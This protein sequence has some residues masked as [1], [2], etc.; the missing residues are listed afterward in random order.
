MATTTPSASGR[1]TPPARR[2][3]EARG[4]PP[5]PPAARSAAVP[6]E[7][8]L[9]QAREDSLLQLRIGRTAHYYTVV[10]YLLFLA[11]GYAIVAVNPYTSPIPLFGATYVLLAPVFGA[12][13]V[14]LFGLW[15]KWE[16]YQL[17]PWEF[18]FWVTVVAV[19]VSGFGAY[20]VAAHL[21]GFGPT[22]AY[23]LLPD[24]VPL[25][26]A[27][28]SL[29]LVGL[30]L[31]WGEWTQ[32]KIAAVTASLLPVLLALDLFVPGSAG[33]PTVLTLTLV[34]GGGLYLVAGSILHLI[35]S[36][37]HA[38][39][40]EMIISGQSRLFRFSDDLR[41]REEALRFRE[42]ALFRREA[43]V[44]V[45]E[46]ALA[47]RLLADADV[48]EQLAQLEKELETRTQ[49]IHEN[50]RTASLKLS[51]ATQTE[52]ELA[53]REAQLQLREQEVIRRETG[54]NERETALAAGE[55]ALVRRQLELATHERE[56]QQRQAALPLEES[57]LEARRQELDR[58][59][60]RL[61]AREAEIASRIP[62]A[63]GSS[64]REKDLLEREA[65]LEQAKAVLAE[66]SSQVNRRSRE[67]EE[68]RS[69]ARRMLEEQ[70]RREESLVER[71]HSLA[72]R[73][74]E[75]DRR[76]ESA[77]A[78][79]KEYAEALARV[80]AR[81]RDLEAAQERVQ[82]A[83]EAAR[84]RLA[85]LTSR[86]GALQQID[87]ELR[88]NRADLEEG[89]HALVVRER[90]LDALESEISL[91]RQSGP[92]P[93]AEPRPSSPAGDPR[94][95]APGV[96]AGAAERAA[97]GDRRPGSRVRTGAPT[98]IP[99]L[100]DLLGGGL[101]PAAQVLL[102]GPPF[103]GKEV[104]LYGFLAEGLKRGESVLLVTTSRSPSETVPEIGLVS[105]QFREYEQ[106]G[107]VHWID[108]SNPSAAPSAGD[109]LDGAGLRAVVKGPG[110][111]PGILAAVTSLLGARATGPNPPKAFRVAV[112]DLS[113]WL[114]H[115]G[116]KEGLAFLRSLI[117][118]LK[119]A[120]A[121]G[122]YLIDPAS[123]PEGQVEGTLSRMDGAV[124]F[125]QDR[126]RTQLTL[127]GLGLEAP[128]DWIDYRSTNHS[129]TLGSFA[130]ERIR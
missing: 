125:R 86:A 60:E 52:R 25:L 94:P 127:R 16:V 120:G 55:G 76:A 119:E 46:A 105:P 67:T 20:L 65:R 35:S 75:V 102:V 101:P 63:A 45:A 82:A 54:R 117:G 130:L 11:D 18:H 21:T 115:G 56:F 90:E 39:E 3:P 79:E 110:D 41:G 4:S 22:A 126:T 32:R 103:L 27:G 10:L 109:P 43:D 128:Q 23:P 68:R 124:M 51:Q 84:D 111:F 58:V 57:R 69:E 106:M 34:A 104:M 5:G 19:P 123:V 87:E 6:T 30:A 48:K 66:Q 53:D 96:P 112:T 36:G 24:A 77:R 28:I 92:M 29:G 2:P 71:E 14:A 40:R 42:V 129:L 62:A 114:A 85:K 97:A 12:L 17:W 83:E 38:H 26:L 33:R 74:A 15:V 37:T 7:K 108:A 73:S 118:R 98:G 49:R 78:H 81:A 93:G 1:E 70:V 9:L 8:D 47:R 89:R 50:L 113:P 88:K 91:R 121:L 95:G 116:E 100:D 99:R 64:D 122:M 61:L 72:L 31:T 59:S 107:R 80:E 13:L 44:E